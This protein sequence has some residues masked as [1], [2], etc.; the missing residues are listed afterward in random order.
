MQER[1]AATLETARFNT[2]LLVTLGGVGLLLAAV[3]IYGVIA[4]FASQRTSEIGIRMAL[5]ASRASVLKLMIRQAAIPVLVGVL[6]GAVAAFFATRVIATQLVN[7]QATDPVTFASRFAGAL[8]L[9]ADFFL[10]REAGTTAVERIQLVPAVG[11]DRM[12]HAAE[13]RPAPRSRPAGC[14]S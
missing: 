5:G 13:R 10:H 12:R 4:Y 7:V 8:K 1:M 3:G 11:P 9:A 14:R 6:L 2:M